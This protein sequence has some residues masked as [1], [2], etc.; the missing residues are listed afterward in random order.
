MTL[1][2]EQIVTSMHAGDLG[3][4]IDHIGQ[5]TYPN[6][7]LWHGRATYGFPLFSKPK[8]VPDWFFQVTHKDSAEAVREAL[9][10]LVRKQI[11][12]RRWTKVY[13]AKGPLS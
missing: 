5:H 1:T 3:W 11:A 4:R 6:Q 10:E 13:K 12:K 9:V 2:L 8:S 7:H